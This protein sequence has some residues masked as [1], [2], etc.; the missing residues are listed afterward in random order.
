MLPRWLSPLLRSWTGP[1]TPRSSPRI[2]AEAGARLLQNSSIS[3]KRSYHPARYRSMQ[4]S[5]SF[6][7]QGSFAITT[8]RSFYRWLTQLCAAIG[9]LTII[10][11]WT[12]IISW[13]GRAYS[14]PIMQP[15]GDILILLSAA[16]DDRGGISYSSYWRARHA[17]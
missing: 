14:G 2:A 6:R 3:S 8:V 5:H 15:K 13:W 11:I 10:V 12:P 7:S 17:L 16:A 9:L 1:G 4:A